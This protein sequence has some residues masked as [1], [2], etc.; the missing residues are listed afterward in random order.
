NIPFAENQRF[1]SEFTPELY[2]LKAS[3]QSGNSTDEKIITVG[4]RDFKASGQH[5][6]L[7]GRKIFLRG[8]V[9]AAIFPLTGYPPMTREQ[10]LK[11][12]N[13]YK[14]YGL[15]HVR[16]HSWC[17]PEAAFAAA[18]E[19]GFMLQVESPLWE[20]YGLVGSDI[21]RAAFILREVNRIIETYGNHPSFC[22]MSIGN[23]LGDGS[24]PYLAYLL[25]YMQKKDS[26]HLY[27]TTTH[28]ANPERKDNYFTSAGT[29]KGS[30][31]GAIPFRDFREA[32]NHM[33][34]PLVSHEVGQP[35]MYPDF[36]EIAKFTGHL[37]ARNLEVFKKS[38]EENQLLEMAEDF[39]MASGK[40]LVEIY[41]ENIEAQLRTPNIAGFQLLGLQDFPGQGVA[42]VGILDAFLESKELIEADEFRH[43]CGQTVP[44]LRMRDFIWYNRENFQATVEIAHYGPSDLAGVTPVWRIRDIKGKTYASGEFGKINLPAGKST[45][46]G[47]IEANLKNIKNAEQLTV[48][49]S[50]PGT[51]V[52]NKWNFWVFP[53]IADVN[54]PDDIHLITKWDDH[55]IQ[56][57]QT[58]KK[59]LF[60]PEHERL[61][62]IE[63]ARWD[64]VFWSYQLFKQPKM[65]GM[66]C[67][68]RHPALSGF[69]TAFHSDWQWKNILNNA[70]ALDITGTSK[71][72]KPIVQFIPD[73][74]SNL[75]LSA[76][77]EAQI[78]KGKLLVC[79]IDLL[80]ISE[81][82]P[83]ARQLL[84][85]L[86]SYMESKNF[87][88]V[89]ALELSI[90]NE[91]F[92]DLVRLENE[93]LM[94]DTAN[95][96]LHIVAAGN[97][98]VDKELSDYD[99]IKKWEKGF[100]YQVQGDYFRDWVYSAWSKEHLV[101]KIDCPDDFEGRLY[102]HF[103]DPHDNGRAA[104]IFYCGQ[105]YG[106]ID[107]YDRKG[108]WLEFPVTKE[109]SKSGITLDARVSGGPDVH[110]SQIILVP[111]D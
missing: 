78:E 100:S 44:L 20:G 27:T 41:K 54:I 72:L 111:L 5:F 35:A 4:I 7:N 65:M 80:K 36:N 40:L 81:N 29:S 23:E 110:I 30:T 59:V 92:K 60:I 58:G 51:P 18:D 1:W 84:H 104:R 15:N 3:L 10:W 89:Q 66:I 56:L 95:A 108:V 25:D 109:M 21:D 42:T 73:F 8:E 62:H 48:E 94:P 68:P 79:N 43:F 38:L 86:I 61:E 57:L 45:R 37:K 71:S 98:A 33:D 106:P 28:P 11:V 101:I 9:N 52:M 103:Y 67:D 99:Q 26:R 105:D 24:D 6:E 93:T 70:E 88:P 12:F 83:A 74:N 46:A 77:M 75:K 31:R 55:A 49:I 22:L 76:I 34:R 16:F 107:R 13:T 87:R 19:A 97:Y 32:L 63:K 90:A 17:P 53:E 2:Q 47:S 82:D 69:P 91:L 96:V 85:S 14:D 50:V 64:P 102:V 39:R